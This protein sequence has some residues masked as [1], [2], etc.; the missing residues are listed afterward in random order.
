[1]STEN[2]EKT[3]IKDLKKQVDQKRA[4]IQKDRTK[5]NPDGRLTGFELQGIIQAIQGQRDEKGNIVQPGIGM[6]QGSSIFNTKIVHNF[7]EAKDW[8][9][10]I[11]AICPE[12]TD[13]EKKSLKKYNEERLALAKK[14]AG[15]PETENVEQVTQQMLETAGNW[16]IFQEEE[17][18]LKDKYSDVLQKQAEVDHE[19][20]RIM[21]SPLAKCDFDEIKR[22]EI[23]DN[24]TAGQLEP[25]WPMIC[26]NCGGQK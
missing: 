8:L 10:Y 14:N 24:L 26:S 9:E 2:N 22:S 16:E 7:K 23:P 25:L 18:E 6:K 19:T 15:I 20:R 11:Q 13:E 1:M 3:P 5:E 12:L 17:K 21:L 4:E